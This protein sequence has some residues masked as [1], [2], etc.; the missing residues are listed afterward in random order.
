MPD[1]PIALLPEIT[2]I[3]TDTLF[4]VSDG[5]TTYKVK[6]GNTSGD[7]AHGQFLSTVDQ[8]I[9]GTT[10]QSYI[11]SAD[12][13]IDSEGVTVVDGSKF[14]FLSGG[15][16]NFAFSSQLIKTTGAGAY[17]ISIWLNQNGTPLIDSTGDVV[18]AGTPISSPLIAAW[19]YL[20]SVESGDN[21]ELVWSSD[22][23]DVKLYAIPIRSNPSRP[24]SPSVSVIITQL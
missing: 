7:A 22:V 19:T 23:A 6:A 15:T 5:G 12:T 20:L 24:T 4:V 3:T 11:M 16:Y 2:G 8:F 13:V 9:T 21:V 10:S 1:L 18:L 14:T 17:T